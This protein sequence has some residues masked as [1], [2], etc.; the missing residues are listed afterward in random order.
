M[1][2][3]SQKDKKLTEAKFKKYREQATTYGFDINFKTIN[4]WEDIDQSGH[5]IHGYMKRVGGELVPVV[6]D[7]GPV[8]AADRN[9]L[10]KDRLSGADEYVNHLAIPAGQRARS[11]LDEELAGFMDVNE[12]ENEDVPLSAVRARKGKDIGAER[13]AALAV[14][15]QGLERAADRVEEQ[16]QEAVDQ[17]AQAGVDMGWMVGGWDMEP[18]EPRQPTPPRVAALEAMGQV[19]APPSPTFPP[20]P[21]RA[22]LSQA[23]KDLAVQLAAE[24]AITKSKIDRLQQQLAELEPVLALGPPSPTFPPA[25]RRVRYNTEFDDINVD[26]DFKP[27]RPLPLPAAQP[28][29][30]AAQRPHRRAL[31]ESIVKPNRDEPVPFAR[32]SFPEMDVNALSRLTD[33]E[34]KQMFDQQ[35]FREDEAAEAADIGLSFPQRARVERTATGGFR[36]VGGQPSQ[37]FLAGRVSSRALASD[38][39]PRVKFGWESPRDAALAAMGQSVDFDLD[40]GDAG[41]YGPAP[42]AKQKKL[43]TCGRCGAPTL[44]GSGCRSKI[45]CKGGC[46]YCWRHSLNFQKGRGCD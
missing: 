26:E 31:I 16:K 27:N 12:D 34:A 46:E 2:R 44:K 18:A 41:G 22:K 10:L 1:V 32:D 37:P 35:M 5:L 21:R 36:L 13:K 8:R 17:M 15:D 28:A 11:A 23:Q 9:R 24:E 30:V 39:D 6:E 29:P 19:E 45:A 3:V 43:L 38:V 7:R 33:E 42:S 20:A 40:I 14:L 4:A 25:P